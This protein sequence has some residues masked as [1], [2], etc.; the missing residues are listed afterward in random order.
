[1]DRSVLDEVTWCAD[2]LKRIVIASLGLIPIQYSERQVFH[3]QG[4]AISNNEHEDQA[5]AHG[6]RRAHGIAP[7]LE[8]LPAGI[9]EHPPKVETETVCLFGS[10]PSSFSC[11]S[12][13]R[14]RMVGRYRRFG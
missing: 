3:V 9:A 13:D 8:R 10:G 11:R 4:D 5:A 14:Y 2:E 6:Q 1:M 7:Q 12:T